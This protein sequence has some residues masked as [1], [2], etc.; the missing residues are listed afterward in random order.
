MKIFKFLKLAVA[1]LGSLVGLNACSA[2][3]SEPASGLYGPPP[4]YRDNAKRCCAKASA[5]SSDACVE[6]Y[7]AVGSSNTNIS[8]PDADV[9]GPPP[10]EEEPYDEATEE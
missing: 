1:G 6:E 3:I 5:D 8:D 2:N 9:Y 4:S 10:F 7:K